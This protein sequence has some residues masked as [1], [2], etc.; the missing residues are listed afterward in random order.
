MGKKRNEFLR[1]Q[2]IKGE[3]R[4]AAGR[5]LN[6]DLCNQVPGPTFEDD[7][8]LSSRGQREDTPTL[9]GLLLLRV[10]VTR[11]ANTLS[12]ITD[13]VTASQLV[14]PLVVFVTGGECVTIGSRQPEH[15]PRRPG[16]GDKLAGATFRG[17]I[18]TP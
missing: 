4:D 8:K 17:D 1:N 3:A 13:H 7:E 18:S 9:P 11:P 2:R 15:V 12:L 6:R 16:Y 10:P 5:P 14:D